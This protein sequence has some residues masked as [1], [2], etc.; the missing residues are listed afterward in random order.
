MA[1]EAGSTKAKHS[2]MLPQTWPGAFNLYQYSK[3]VVY[4]N[5]QT[6][7]VIYL[8][9]MVLGAATYPFG[10]GR[11]VL[12]IIIGAI[13]SVALAITFLESFKKNKI[14][15]GKAISLSWPDRKSVV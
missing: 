14:E 15:V 10:I 9:S 11:N 6:I 8:V 5:W 13:A 1:N 4:Y 7:L 3:N 2:E 12:S